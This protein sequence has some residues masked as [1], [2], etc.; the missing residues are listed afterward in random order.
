MLL[1]PVSSS[2]NVLLSLN[3]QLRQLR[4]SRLYNVNVILHMFSTQISHMMQVCFICFWYVEHV[5][6]CCA[7]IVY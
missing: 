2:T 3:K 4:Q 1:L 6:I 7:G 5:R